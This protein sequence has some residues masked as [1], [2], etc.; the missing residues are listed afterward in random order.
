NL[1]IVQDDVVIT[2][3]YVAPD[4]MPDGPEDMN[5]PRVSLRVDEESGSGFI[6]INNHQRKRHMAPIRD[7][8]VTINLPDGRTTVVDGINVASDD[9]AVIPF[10]LRFDK[11]TW[12]EATNASLLAKVGKYFFFYTSDDKGEVYFDFDEEES[13]DIFLLSKEEAEH[14]YHIGDKLYITDR[15]LIEEN[16]MVYVLTSTDCK[17]KVYDEEGKLKTVKVKASYG[18]VNE[19]YLHVDFDGDRAAAYDS[20]GRLLTDWF[21]NGEE[22]VIATKRYG[23][24]TGLDIRVEPYEDGIYYDLPPK[25]G[26][27]INKTY[28]ETEYKVP[29]I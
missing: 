10:G 17:I 29:V 8:T 4:V 25:R 21:S 2:E 13:E 16:G 9:T 12:L 1:A 7:L 14:A 11:Y 23:F 28:V 27:Q 19:K 3:E 20:Q 6:F 22:W 26:C 5:T 24:E 15:Q 18:E